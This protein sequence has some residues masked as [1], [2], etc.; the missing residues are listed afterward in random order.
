MSK[1][2]VVASVFRDG[3]VR[4][5]TSRR[6]GATVLCAGPIDVV[7]DVVSAYCVL[8]YRNVGYLLPKL[9]TIVDDVEAMDF[10]ADVAKQMQV[11]IAMKCGG[12]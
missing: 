6:D 10:M 8:C 7:V 11:D 4:I 9:A 12:V 2:V 5:D 1:Q 3:V